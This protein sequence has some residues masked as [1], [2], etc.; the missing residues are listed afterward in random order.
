[1]KTGDKVSFLNDVGGGTVAGFRGKDIVLVE[2]EDGFQIPVKRNEVV[3]IQAVDYNTSSM[4]KGQLSRTDKHPANAFDDVEK[5]SVSAMLRDG[6]EEE[7]DMSAEDT[8][9]DN[10]EVTFRARPQERKGGDRLAAYLAFVPIDDRSVSNPRYEVYLV[11]DS[12]YYMRFA[13]STATG[14]QWSLKADGEIE[15]NTKTFVDETTRED[16]GQLGRVA[17][18]LMAYKRDGAFEIKPAIDAILR[19]DALKF[20]KIHAFRV[21]PFF[22]E[23][24]LLYTIVENDKTERPRDIDAEELKR[25]MFKDAENTGPAEQPF[26]VYRPSQPVGRYADNQRK[27]NKKNSPYMHRHGLDDAVV[28][29]LHAGQILDSTKGMSSGEILDYQLKVFRETLD[30]LATKKIRKV[31]FIHGKGEGVLRRAII[32][33]LKYKYKSYTYQDASFQEFGYGATMVTV[34]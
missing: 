12:N 6:Q 8:V 24:S 30:Q 26:S 29:D 10:K 19:I 31:V 23:P 9:D 4:V 1:M 2:D 14:G 17:V 5:R 20:H 13:C 7:V 28:V 22:D 25:G 11:N 18:Q 15:P 32:N 16:A 27:G 21:N 34:R 3:V 33:E